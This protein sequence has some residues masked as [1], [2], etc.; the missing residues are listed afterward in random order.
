MTI[1]Q[2]AC[3]LFHFLSIFCSLTY[4]RNLIIATEMKGSAFYYFSLMYNM[5]RIVNFIVLSKQV[6]LNQDSWLRFVN[7]ANAAT[8]NKLTR[9]T[10]P[11]G[12]KIFS[13]V[14]AHIICIL[15]IF[16][17]TSLFVWDFGFKSG[18]RLQEEVW[19]STLVVTGRFSFFVGNRTEVITSWDEVSEVDIF[20]SV[21]AAN[22]YLV[23]YI[24][25]Y[26][27][28]ELIIP[29]VVLTIWSVV[30]IFI[31]DLEESGGDEILVKW[32]KVVTNFESI[33]I[34]L[35]ETK[36]A[37]G[38]LLI[39][40]VGVT[41][42]R[43]TMDLN[44][45]LESLKDSVFIG[46]CVIFDCVAVAVIILAADCSAQV[47]IKNLNGILKFYKIKFNKHFL[48]GR[49]QKLD[50]ESLDRAATRKSSGSLE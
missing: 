26:F 44:Y 14:A 45:M 42:L 21:I 31:Q 28:I 33:R 16:I 9:G 40:F 17:A 13:R 5:F 10:N 48:D 50:V 15:Y 37:F 19:Y 3:G 6:W 47:D 24:S 20:V 29:L 38:S 11:P 35:E 36:V 1:L 39:V 32:S 43:I 46:C 30:N 34:L 23:G 27:V 41:I 7:A 49:F 18:A 22:A 2:V 8:E 4:F 12:Y 25:L